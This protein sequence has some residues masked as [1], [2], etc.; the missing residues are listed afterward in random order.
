MCNRIYAVQLAVLQKIEAGAPYGLPRSETAEWEK[1]HM[2]SSAQTGAQLAKLRGANA[3]LAAIACS[4]HDIG[5][6]VFGKQEGHA[7]AGYAPAKELL[8]ALGGFAEEEI[9]EIAVAVRNH[10]R[11][12]EVGAPLE[13]IVKD[14]DVLDM[15]Y[16]GRALP[17]EE[18]RRRLDRLRTER[19]V[20]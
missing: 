12:A 8:A 11:K 7:E 15:D 14:A 18:Q 2:A 19:R 16:Y 3:E 4:L 9:E 17:R 10:S 20:L 5:R 1:I 6:I 13:E